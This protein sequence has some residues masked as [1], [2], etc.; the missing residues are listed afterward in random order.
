MR[1][2]TAAVLAAVL[3]GALGGCGTANNLLQPEY[4]GEGQEPGPVAKHVY[5][6]VG[7][8]A[9]VGSA[10]LA[11]PFVEKSPPEVGAAEKVVETTCKVGIGAYVLGVDLPLSAVADTLTLPLTVPA[12]LRQ[13]GEPAAKDKPAARPCPAVKDPDDDDSP[14]S[15]PAS[16]HP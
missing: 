13:L 2:R 12:T 4:K 16:R 10:W 11:A 6:G 5:G 3:A 15:E 8:D 1:R 7:L 14:A 9:K